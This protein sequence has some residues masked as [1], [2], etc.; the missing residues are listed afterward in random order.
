M[1]SAASV[2][3]SICLFVCQHDSSRTIK[4]RIMKNLAIRCIVQK[5]R[6]SS[7]LGVKG[8]GSRSPGTK[9]DKVRHFSGAVSRA[10]S[11]G[12]CVRCMFGKTS[13]IFSIAGAAGVARYHAITSVSK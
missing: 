3:L 8:Q 4:P 6:S 11:S 9:N 13:N 2:C 1:F 10:R 5:S 7:N 12:P